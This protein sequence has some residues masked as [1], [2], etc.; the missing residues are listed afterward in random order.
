M[1]IFGR[2]GP[3]KLWGQ[4]ERAKLGPATPLGAYCSDTASNELCGLK[5]HCEED[6]DELRGLGADP[7]S[8]PAPSSPL[9]SLATAV[10]AIG[11]LWYL[12]KMTAKQTR[13]W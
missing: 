5:L 8:A 9:A 2:Q 4:G 13:S 10:I 7:V 11:G 6:I 3:P 1:Y 12:T